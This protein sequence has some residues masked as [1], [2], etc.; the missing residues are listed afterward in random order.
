MVCGAAAVGAAVLRR[1]CKF[2]TTRVSAYLWQGGY[3]TSFVYKD[4]HKN[5]E[6]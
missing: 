6:K 1:T 5:P 3:I 2:A 4:Y